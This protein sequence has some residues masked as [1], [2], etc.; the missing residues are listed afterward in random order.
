MA[1]A[2]DWKAKHLSSLREM[3][4]EERRWRELEKVLRRLVN[5]L[6][7]AAMGI[8]PRLDAQLSKLAEANRRNAE[9][10][11]L[12]A[13]HDSLSD[14]LKALDSGVG[15]ATVTDFT[16]TIPV[17]RAMLPKAAPPAAA[18]TASAGL[19]ALRAAAGKLVER[20][21]ASAPRDPRVQELKA[22]LGTARDDAALAAVL[23]NVADVVAEFGADVARERAVAVAILGQ[24]TERLDEMAG[25]IGGLNKDQK[26]RL[27]DADVLNTSVLSQVTSLTSAARS[28]TDIGSL[29]SLVAERLEGVAS[30]V[31]DFRAR[32]GERFVEHTARADAMRARI[33][34]LEI[35]S[36]D[37]TR[38]LEMER[39]RSRID[40][41]TKVANRAAF[42]ERLL[43][44]LARLQR[45]HTPVTLVLWDI[46]RFKGINDSYGHRV[47]DA[48][49]REVAGCLAARIRTTD[50]VARYGGEEFVML[51]V[52]TALDEAVTLV[53]TLRQAIGGM[54]FHFKGTPVTVTASCG[55][56][57]LREN[58]TPPSA[59]DR[60]DGALYSAKNQGR[61]RYVT[62]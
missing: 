43:E 11:E 23:L 3:E 10:T 51:L 34:E 48:V 36:R 31:R 12:G 56:T 14:A 52:G 9:V 53:E 7:A 55:V 4:V 25:Y 15:T 1:E 33:E 19:P 17:T 42:D 47:G 39:R 20:L 62:A 30:Q 46:D 21:A 13:R 60:A 45:L 28:A 61:N 59:F 41:L 5:R 35:E 49:L 22:R 27:D 8:E 24:V 2:T 40:P 38:S 58:D 37:L 16:A 18:A 50:F 26:T 29:R 6:C 54:G 44:E 57:A 32:E